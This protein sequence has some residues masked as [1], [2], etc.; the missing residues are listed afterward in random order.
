VLDVIIQIKQSDQ[1]AFSMHMMAGAILEAGQCSAEGTGDQWRKAAAHAWA[2]WPA[3]WAA[4]GL[5]RTLVQSEGSTVV[6]A[7]LRRFADDEPW[8][9]ANLARVEAFLWKVSSP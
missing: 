7:A 3:R 6:H 1:V 4:A 9:A 5:E 8:H 2:D